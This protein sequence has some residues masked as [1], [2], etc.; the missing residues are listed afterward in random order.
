MTTLGTA[1]L[2][3][4]AMAVAVV[5]VEWVVPA[6][7]DED[8]DEEVGIVVAVLITEAVVVGSRVPY[9]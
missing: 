1:A 6:C 2:L 4:V 8:E 9:T 5:S 7:K 3:T